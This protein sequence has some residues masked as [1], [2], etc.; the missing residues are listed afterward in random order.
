M[1]IFHKYE[2]I[3]VHIPKT[4]GTT[5]SFSLGLNKDRIHDNNP[6]AQKHWLYGPLSVKQYG[7][8]YQHLT[9]SQIKQEVGKET[10]NE[11][12]KFSFVRNPWDRIVSEFCWAQQNTPRHYKGRNNKF[13][14]LIHDLENGDVDKYNHRLNSQAC[15]LKNEQGEMDMDFVGRFENFENDWTRLGAKLGFP[16]VHNPDTY[17]D[18]ML[19]FIVNN[20]DKEIYLR[21][22][23][24]KQIIR[25]EPRGKAPA[26][27][28][29][30][31]EEK[32]N[33]ES[34]AIEVA[35]TEEGMEKK[36]IYKIDEIDVN[37]LRKTQNMNIRYYHDIWCR[38]P[39][40]WHG[41]MDEFFNFDLGLKIEQRPSVDIIDPLII[42]LVRV[43]NTNKGDY[44]KYYN[45]WS[46][47]V[48]GRYY[49]EDIDTFKYTF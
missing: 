49:E 33:K 36:Q 7:L 27:S 15:F 42:D 24:Q 16:L 45:D 22:D 13:N 46:K 39:E 11:Y 20:S 19:G 43:F 18:G 40:P 31:I 35:F 21:V 6:D 47:G 48:V 2:A 1:P 17:K 37:L 23:K 29:D 26:L 32:K 38:E 9:A 30:L 5:V 3:Q 25:V 44:K 28:I 8:P 12:F 14:E 34:I 4:A 41:Y 10:Y